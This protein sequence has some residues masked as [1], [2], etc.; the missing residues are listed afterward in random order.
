MTNEP[1]WSAFPIEAFERLIIPEL[2]KTCVRCIKVAIRKGFFGEV[3]GRAVDELD[4]Y[5]LERFKEQITKA[6]GYLALI[7]RKRL[8]LGLIVKDTGPV[9][10][11]RISA[12]MINATN[13]GRRHL[14]FEEIRKAING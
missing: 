12:A 1:F 9:I 3:L 7:M 5:E 4:G 14:T 13:A 8:N 6:D 11:A 2:V 10:D